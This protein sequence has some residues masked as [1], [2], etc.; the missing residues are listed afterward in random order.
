M[1]YEKIDDDF[2]APY[3]M[4]WSDCEASNEILNKFPQME[5]VIIH[6]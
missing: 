1:K 5:Y 6:D 4:R 2:F 3:S